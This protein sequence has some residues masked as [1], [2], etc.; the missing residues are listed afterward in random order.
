MEFLTKLFWSF[1]YLATFGLFCIIIQ[2]LFPSNKGQKTWRKDSK[3]DFCYWLFSNL[4]TIYLT[5]FTAVIVISLLSLISPALE[6]RINSNISESLTTIGVI[7]ALIMLDFTAYWIH[8]IFHTGR[9]WNYHSIHHS[10]REIDWLSSVRFHPLESIVIIVLSYSACIIGGL[11]F[12][13]VATALAIRGAYGYIVHA[14]VT[15]HYGPL[16]YIIAS[17][18]FH[19]WHHTKDREG[20]DKNFAGVF[21]LWDFIFGTAYMPKARQPGNFGIKTDIGESFMQH[22]VYPFRKKRS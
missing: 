15:W 2:K 7:L 9:L 1:I 14:N 18:Y 5:A 16:S 8:R 21:S 10:S 13:D 17:P 4:I 6:R 12:K 3:V 22:L 20:I 19:R 11:G